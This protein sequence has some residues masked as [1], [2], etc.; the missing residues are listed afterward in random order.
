MILLLYRPLGQTEGAIGQELEKKVSENDNLI[1]EILH[2]KKEAHK[3]LI[4][5]RDVMKCDVGENQKDNYAD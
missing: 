3:G 4:E 1:L 5:I 2:T